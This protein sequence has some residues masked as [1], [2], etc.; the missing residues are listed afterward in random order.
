M[1]SITEIKSLRSQVKAW[2]QQG[3]SIAFVPTMGNL[4]QGHF[5]LVEKAKTL[6]D[7]VVVSIFVNPMQ[8]GKN[9]D[10]DSYPRTL[11]QD[12]QG[13]A[14]LG[15]DIVFTPS[16]ETI[17]PN[18]LA[19][20]SFV[21]V[22]GVSEGYCGGAREGHFRGVATVVTKL[23]NLVQPD[24]ACFGEKDYQQLQVIKTMVHDLSMPIE[25][26]G[27]PTQREVTGL[28]MSSRNGYLSEQEKDVAKVLYK[29]LSQTAAALKSGVRQFDNLESEAKSELEQAGL[30]PDYFSIAHRDTLKPAQ[31][32]DEH[33]VVL[34][35][36]FL[37]SV[38]LIDNIQVVN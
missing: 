16:V 17:Y 14:E 10:L 20:Q 1:Q 8:F 21:D 2:R 33:F 24:F 32:S 13:L 15:T 4:H 36:A 37:G 22:P 6:A 34:A 31:Q 25:I 5:S 23:F 27:V 35:A 38:R 9:E 3:H 12:K 28:A 29:V 30:K 11:V 7:K 26:I 18:G 19:T